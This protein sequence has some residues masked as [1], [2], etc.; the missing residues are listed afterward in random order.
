M[1]PVVV[2]RFVPCLP[3][4]RD[5]ISALFFPRPLA[6][7]SYGANCF[8]FFCGRYF[9]STHPLLAGLLLRCQHRL[10]AVCIDRP[11]G[12]VR[13]PR[14]LD[15]QSARRALGARAKRREDRSDRRQGQSVSQSA[16]QLIKLFFVCRVR[17]GG[18][19]FVCFVCFVCLF[20]CFCCCRVVLC[21]VVRCWC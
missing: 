6:S 19:C 4:Y 17:F 20:V 1:T 5:N 9:S 3:F 14:P 18:V 2:P 11:L 15:R 21:G 12:A 10:R 16:A 13:R 8:V 7:C